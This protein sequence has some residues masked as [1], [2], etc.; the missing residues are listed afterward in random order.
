MRE[1]A[2]DLHI[3]TILSPCA[4]DDMTPPQILRRV[5]ELGIEVVAITDHNSAENVEAFYIKGKEMGV[6]V[7]SGMEVQTREDI[8]LICLF[9]TLEQVFNWEKAVY[10]RLPDLKN[11]KESFGAQWL[12]DSEGNITGEVD[13][14]LLMGADLSLTEVVNGV[15]AI[16]GLCIAAHIDRRAFSLWGSLGF[17]P[18]R[19]A[20]DNVELTPHLARNPDQLAQLR[21]KGFNYLISSDAH[22][23]DGIYPPQCFA[24]IEEF[25]IKELKAA[26]LSQD[27]R[28]IRTTR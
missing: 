18:D 4:G 2:L 5:K 13:R 27:G 7:V 11:R 20:I 15:H 23:L 26:F 6:K 3:H 17:I 19:P 25:S 1:W 12:V 28:Y 22:Y 8:H 16:G 10:Q 21:E 9:D 24:R 14:L